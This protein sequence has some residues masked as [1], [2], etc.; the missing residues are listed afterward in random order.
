M[1]RRSVFARRCSRD[2]ATLVA[3]M[4]CAL[5]LTCSQPARQPK[6]VPAGLK[7]HRDA[8]DC[9]AGPGC[10]VLPTTQKPQ[11][12]R[13]IGLELFLLAD[14]RCPARSRQPTSSTGSS[15]SRQPTCCAAPEGRG[16]CSGRSTVPW[17]APRLVP[18]GT[19]PSFAAC[20]IASVG[21]GP[22][23]TAPGR[24]VRWRTRTVGSA[25]FCRAIAT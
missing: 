8:G 4:T 6:A 25:G 17:S 23:P 10:L 16:I 3:W 15:R 18:S 21:N 14:A 5:D 11:Q 22:I 13:G 12:R 24:K 1:S 9:L 20:P 19:V 7:S 2:T